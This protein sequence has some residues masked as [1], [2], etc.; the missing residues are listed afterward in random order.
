MIKGNQ[1][2]VGRICLNPKIF[3]HLVMALRLI[4]PIRSIID[5][6]LIER[7]KARQ[8]IVRASQDCL[9]VKTEIG[10]QL[11]KYGLHVKWKSSNSIQFLSYKIIEIPK[12]MYCIYWAP[13]DLN[14]WSKWVQSSLLLLNLINPTHGV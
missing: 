10:R 14:I 12:L 4:M 7:W 11:H 13:C 2:F 3:Q 5:H 6:I 8:P 9:C 1:L